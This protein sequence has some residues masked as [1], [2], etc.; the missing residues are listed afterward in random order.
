MA[1]LLAPTGKLTEWSWRTA[2][3]K[4]IIPFWTLSDIRRG[5]RVGLLIRRWTT[6]PG[7]VDL[8]LWVCHLEGRWRRFNAWVNIRPSPWASRLIPKK[9]VLIVNRK[10]H[11]RF[12][13]T[14]RNARTKSGPWVW[15]TKERFFLASGWSWWTPW[16]S[17]LSMT[18]FGSSHSF[19]WHQLTIKRRWQ[20]MVGI[21]SPDR[22]LGSLAQFEKTKEPH[23]QLN[24]AFLHTYVRSFARPLSESLPCGEIL[25]V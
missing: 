9:S 20:K 23:M 22:P 24:L 13:N 2:V 11:S 10:L 18:Q 14:K 17:S 6:W 1:H 15:Y 12:Y 3:K 7:S 5:V 4:W 21:H 8:L 25:T 16:S 19:S